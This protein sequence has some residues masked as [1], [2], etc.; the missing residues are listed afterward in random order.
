MSDSQLPETFSCPECKAEGKNI[1]HIAFSSYADDRDSYKLEVV[2]HNAKSKFIYPTV[3]PS[4][5]EA[6]QF[7]VDL[8][9]EAQL[10]DNDV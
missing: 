10:G 8:V 4:V 5:E 1:I 7:L 3:F 6:K 2:D 9:T